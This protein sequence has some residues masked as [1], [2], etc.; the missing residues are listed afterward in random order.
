MA[1]YE[2]FSVSEVAAKL[3]CSPQTVRVLIYKGV[4]PAYRVGK[5]FRIPK[6]ALNSLRVKAS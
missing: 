2:L 3:A 1:N 4:L 6:M 5:V